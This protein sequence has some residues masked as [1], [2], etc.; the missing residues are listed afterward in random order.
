[1]DD[2]VTDERRASRFE[3]GVSGSTP[4]LSSGGAPGVEGRHGLTCADAVKPA[5]RSPI[6]CGVVGGRSMHM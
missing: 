2:D 4:L 3:P 5:S 1:M 6:R